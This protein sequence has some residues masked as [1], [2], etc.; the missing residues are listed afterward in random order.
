[1][2]RV[3]VIMLSIL[4]MCLASCSECK[5]KEVHTQK[6]E[7]GIIT[8]GYVKAICKKCGET[9]SEEAIPATRSIK[10]LAIGNSFSEDATEYLYDL[11]KSAGVENVIIGNASIGGCSID[12]H[13][14]M[15]ESDEKEYYYIKFNENGKKITRSTLETAVEDEK[16]DVVTLQQVSTSSGRPGD[17]TRLSDLIDYVQRTSY[18]LHVD[19]KFH[20]TWA[21]QQ[22][23][24]HSKFVEYYGN[25]QMTMY[26]AIVETMKGTVQPNENITGIIPS[27]TA[28][29][30]LR[31]SYLGD[32]VTRDG[33]HL[34]YDI[35]RY[36]AGLAWA[37]FLTGISPYDINWYPD[38]YPE[39]KD[40]RDAICEAVENAIAHPFEVT[41]SVIT[42]KEPAS[43]E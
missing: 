10:L 42:E 11:L 21:Y 16:W 41:N 24:K 36:T 22:D 12:K 1:M 18:N 32:T 15:S 8:D 30:N 28:V 39:I 13:L 31:T 25:D 35:G 26:N 34:S 17:Y 7:A 2:K 33:T 5:H 4:T 3:I 23:S 6:L 20:M 29:Q 14:E 43:A 27:G 9:V 40:A 19:F 37:C 38:K